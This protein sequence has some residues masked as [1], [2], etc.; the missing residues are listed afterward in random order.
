MIRERRSGGYYCGS[1]GGGE[2]G[3]GEEGRREPRRGLNQQEQVLGQE[4]DGVPGDH[5]EEG[6]VEVREAWQTER[7]EACRAARDDRGIIVCTGQLLDSYWWLF[8][9]VWCWPRVP[10]VQNIG[11]VWGPCD[12]W[13]LDVK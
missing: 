2:G 4:E 3:A 6:E 5:G 9:R 13:I 7:V 12:S 1:Q 10:E 11:L 8:K